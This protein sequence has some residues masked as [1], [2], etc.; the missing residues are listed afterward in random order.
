[1]CFM[2]RSVCALYN[3]DNTRV[4]K[5]R[6]DCLMC[7]SKSPKRIDLSTRDFDLKPEISREQFPVPKALPVSLPRFS[8]F[9][10]PNR[11]NARN[12]FMTV[13]LDIFA[14][15]LSYQRNDYSL[16]Y[17]WKWINKRWING[18]REREIY[19]MGKKDRVIERKEHRENQRPPPICRWLH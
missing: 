13:H 10:L 14:I 7:G 1:M 12:V 2:Y 15:R 3:N 17:R 5:R 8:P 11:H 4:D 16:P 9:S 18:E 19:K 6:F